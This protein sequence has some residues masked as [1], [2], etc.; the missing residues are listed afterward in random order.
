[1]SDIGL[2]EL[3][4]AFAVQALYCRATLPIDPEFYSV[5]GGGISIGHP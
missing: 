1:V 3:N 2:R 5:N 4:E